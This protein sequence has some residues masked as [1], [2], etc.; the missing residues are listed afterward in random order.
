L[1]CW[2]YGV[3]YKKGVEE[4]S[5]DTMASPKNWSRNKSKEGTTE[6]VAGTRLP[7]PVRYAWR[8]NEIDAE[9]EVIERTDM[10]RIY[11]IT[12]HDHRQEMPVDEHNIIG[13]ENNLREA[14]KR[15][16]EWIRNHPRP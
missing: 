4:L 9:V 13:E 3:R 1:R 7:Q 16:V 8:H 10:G 2:G 12:M 15:A 14:Y 11:H 5:F 6:D